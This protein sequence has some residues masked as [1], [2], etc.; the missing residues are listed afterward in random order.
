TRGDHHINDVKVKHFFQAEYAEVCS[1]SEVAEALNLEID[2]I[3]PF[4]KQLN[5]Y[6][7]HAIKEISDGTY[8]LTHA[9]KQIIHLNPGRDL[10]ISNYADFRMIEEGDPSPDGHGAVKFAKGIEIGQ[11]FK[12][13]TEYSE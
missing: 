8:F 4:S 6:A 13:G 7:D 3:S 11:V 5:V 2:D 1:E 12:L 9:Q 10:D